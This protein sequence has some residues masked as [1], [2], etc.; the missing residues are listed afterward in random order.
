MKWEMISMETT[1]TVKIKVYVIVERSALKSVKS[2]NAENQITVGV[3]EAGIV[4]H[5]WFSSSGCHFRRLEDFPP[6][7]ISTISLNLRKRVRR[8]K[9]K[10]EF[11]SP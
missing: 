7:E 9:E 10:T 4:V 5:S 6:G 1:Q 8:R 3:R 11:D 2:S